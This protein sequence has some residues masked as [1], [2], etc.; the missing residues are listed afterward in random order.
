MGFYVGGY[1]D[2]FSKNVLSTN[3][4]TY[5]NLKNLIRKSD[6][7]ILRGDKD[8]NDVMIMNRSDYIQKLEGMIEEGVKKGTYKKQ[9]I[10]PYK[11]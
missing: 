9:K 10:Q 3:N 11:I 7:V 4:E 1:T 6:M 2:I 8:D 5:Q